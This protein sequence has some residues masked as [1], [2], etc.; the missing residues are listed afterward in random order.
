[1]CCGSDGVANTSADG[2][3]D[4]ESDGGTDGVADV[5]T[6]CRAKRSSNGSADCVADGE[7]DGV[8]ELESDRRS[9]ARA[10]FCPDCVADGESDGGALRNADGAT[11]ALA[12]AKPHC[13]AHACVHAWQVRER[14]ICFELHAM[15]S[16]QVQ[17]CVQ[18]GWLHIMSKRTVCGRGDGCVQRLSDWALSSIVRQHMPFVCERPIQRMG[19]TGQLLALSVRQV[20]GQG[21]LPPVPFVQREHVDGG[22][23]W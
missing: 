16:G 1:M 20:P 2:Y 4:S 11:H 14:I 22:Q 23:F 7:S 6:D 10:V 21:G 17:R 12:I 18:R 3:A 9:Y 8:A 15:W 13:L 19:S 5:I